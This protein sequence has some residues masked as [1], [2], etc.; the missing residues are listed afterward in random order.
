M[1]DG[2]ILFTCGLKATSCFWLEAILILEDFAW[3]RIKKVKSSV[4][5]Q[6]SGLNQNYDD[7]DSIRSW[8]KVNRDLIKNVAY[9]I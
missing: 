8:L 3:L 6:Q 5:P 4:I 2:K 1:I 7:I 9:S